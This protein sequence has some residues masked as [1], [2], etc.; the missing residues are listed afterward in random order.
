MHKI[1]NLLLDWEESGISVK[2]RSLLIVKGWNKCADE[3]LERAR[4]I[5]RENAPASRIPAVDQI[6]ATLME[7]WFDLELGE[8]GRRAILYHIARQTELSPSNETLAG[9][10]DTPS[11]RAYAWV[12]E[13][14]GLCGP[15]DIETVRKSIG[16]FKQKVADRPIAALDF[17]TYHIKLINGNSFLRQLD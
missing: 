5:D 7:E 9:S 14:R 13:Q 15:D 1:S 6:C 17:K 10:L 8:G 12:A 16:R 11:Q 3:L 2:R 4:E